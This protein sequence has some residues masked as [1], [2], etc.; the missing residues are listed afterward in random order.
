[1]VCE[2]QPVIHS[3]EQNGFC[4]LPTAGRAPMGAARPGELGVRRKGVSGGAAPEIYTSSLSPQGTGQEGDSPAPRMLF[5][6]GKAEL[7]WNCH[8][9]VGQN[10]FCGGS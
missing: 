6:R 10:W 9:T 3:D 7:C 8:C 1:M 5:G 2:A 4:H